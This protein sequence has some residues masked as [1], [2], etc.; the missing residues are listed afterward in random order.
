MDVFA[1]QKRTS[2]FF[3]APYHAPFAIN[4]VKSHFP[5]KMGNIARLYAKIRVPERVPGR[6]LR[7]GITGLCALT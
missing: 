2:A 7:R 1:S 5:E 3:S 6:D 4:P